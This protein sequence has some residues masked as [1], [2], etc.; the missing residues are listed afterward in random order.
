MRFAAHGRIAIFLEPAWGA[1]P[2]IVHGELV[3]TSTG[4]CRVRHQFGPLAI[5]RKVWLS[6]A[7]EYRAALVVWNSSA[8]DSTETG[9]RFVD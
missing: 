1:V 8:E 6:W 3:D 9:V 2:A 4:G 5:G 7:D